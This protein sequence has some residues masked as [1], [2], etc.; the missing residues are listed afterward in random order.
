MHSRRLI[1][2]YSERTRQGRMEQFRAA[3]LEFRPCR[4]TAR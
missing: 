3:A 2:T 1:P 4:W